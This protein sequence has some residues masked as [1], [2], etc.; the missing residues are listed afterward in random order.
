MYYF[1]IQGRRNSNGKSEDNV[2][3]WP[4]SK[5]TRNF[6]GLLRVADRVDDL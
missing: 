6:I 5:L 3:R 2:R 4:S 1:N